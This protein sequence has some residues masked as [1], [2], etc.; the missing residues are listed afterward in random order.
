[1]ANVVGERFQITI[2]KKVRQELGVRPGDVALERA[3]NGK[4]VVDFVP[5][6]HRESLLGIF[7]DPDLPPIRDWQAVKA[8]AWKG[9][10]QGDPR[11]TARGQRASQIARSR[12]L[13]AS[14]LL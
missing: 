1:M 10:E 6:P 3:E 11:S 12:P 7:R 2:D 13:M 4:L 8:R 14:G 5:A 9:A